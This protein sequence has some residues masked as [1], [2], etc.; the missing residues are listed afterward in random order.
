MI[1]EMNTIRETEP[2]EYPG[3]SLDRGDINKFV[4]FLENKN[5][6]LDDG[7]GVFHTDSFTNW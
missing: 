2:K 1:Q 4:E 3:L 6:Y 5:N 7:M